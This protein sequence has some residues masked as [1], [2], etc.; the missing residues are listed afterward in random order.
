LQ[1]LWIR[2]APSR[3]SIDRPTR[4]FATGEAALD[5]LA[6][7]DRTIA[8]SRSRYAAG[9]VSAGRGEASGD[10]RIFPEALCAA[11][12][13]EAHILA[14]ATCAAASQHCSRIF[15]LRDFVGYLLMIMAFQIVTSGFRFPARAE[16]GGNVG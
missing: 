2:H 5:G 4:S 8:A 6:I 3:A 15:I 16:P 12:N 13:A 14:G 9:I 1:S 10:I 7:R 11:D